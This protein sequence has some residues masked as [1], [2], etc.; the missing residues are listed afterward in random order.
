MFPTQICCGLL[1][2]PLPAPRLIIIPVLD[3]VPSGVSYNRCFTSELS[4][5]LRTQS[6]NFSLCCNHDHLLD[7]IQVCFG[8]SA[9]NLLRS[10]LRI[11]YSHVDSEGDGRKIEGEIIGLCIKI[12]W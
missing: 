9:A 8:T 1:K 2:I 11:H 7:S 4:S 5:V 3:R 10:T 12:M 6:G